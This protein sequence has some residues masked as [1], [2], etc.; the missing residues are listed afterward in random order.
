M[1]NVYVVVVNPYRVCAVRTDYRV[2][3]GS[4][5]ELYDTYKGALE[6]KQSYE[7]G[8]VIPFNNSFLYLCKAESAFEAIGKYWTMQNKDYTRRI[9]DV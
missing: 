7:Y 2:W 3:G 8:D 5:P 1:D 6:R 9:D 4:G